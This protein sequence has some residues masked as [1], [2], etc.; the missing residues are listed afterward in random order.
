MDPQSPPGEFSPAGGG[1]RPAEI[2]LGLGRP[3]RT[4][5]AGCTFSGAECHDRFGGGQEP[6]GKVARGGLR[7]PRERTSRRGGLAAGPRTLA[8]S[9][10]LGPSGCVRLGSH[11]SAVVSDRAP[12]TGPSAAGA[13]GQWR[14]G[15]QP[16]RPVLKHGPRSLACARVM[17]SHET[18]RRNESEGRLRLAQAGSRPLAGRAHCRPVSTASSA[19]RSKS[20]HAG[21]RK[22]VNYA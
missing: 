10:G 15:R 22:M 20:A 6:G 5:P 9:A 18:Q 3:A 13:S 4:P 7:A 11:C 19:R 12:G 21:T 14:I 16:T 2:R 8:A 1:R 17:G